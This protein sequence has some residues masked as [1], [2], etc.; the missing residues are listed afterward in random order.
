[1]PRSLLSAALVVTCAAFLAGCIVFRSADA[2]PQGPFGVV[3]VNAVVCASGYD[4]NAGQGCTDY[5]RSGNAAQE[6]RT[7]RALLGYLVPRGT[8]GPTSFDATLDVAWDAGLTFVSSS[9][10]TRRLD[11][12]FPPPAGFVWLGYHS[13]PFTYRVGSSPKQFSVAADFQVPQGP[14][15]APFA[16]PFKAQVVVGHGPDPFDCGTYCLDSVRPAGEPGA[17]T[18][19]VAVNDAGLLG[20]A[21]VTAARGSTASIPFTLA[22][23]G[24]DPGA[25]LALGA[26]TD[27]PGATATAPGTARPT[28]T[29][30][31]PLTV[32]VPV[33]ADAAPGSYAVTL[34]ASLGGQ[35]RTQTRT[36]VVAGPPENQERPEISGAQQAGSVL[37]GS[38]GT[39]SGTPAPSFSRRWLRCNAG[40][41]ACA[42]IEG[43]TGA[44]HTVSG[45]DV[46][47]TLRLRVTA[48]NAGGV[49]ERD[50]APT[51]TIVALPPV[52]APVPPPVPDTTA[53]G[54]TLS[55]LPK[56]VKRRAFLRGITF[57]VA[58]DEAAALSAGLLASARKVTLARASA[59]E[60]LLG[61]AR[62]A[63]GTGVATLKLR[64]AKRLVGRARRFSVRV[65]VTG[66]DGA[67]N[68][69][70]VRR[71]VKVR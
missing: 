50:S 51:G 20:G 22:Y 32:A 62:A 38:D 31:T 21:P 61:S 39:W 45:A 17:T 23:E 44:T 55:G 58:R 5:G 4:N 18:F 12:S 8:R 57:T 65:E 46:G 60:L 37:T 29:S 19:S 70:T 71:T 53:P 27:L 6:D 1:M 3:R 24:A 41:A 69:A 35:S 49:T 43:A 34:T 2:V 47:R 68:Q 13:N 67:G 10:Y 63:R 25:D 9:G 14:D 52:A 26:S 15:G 36:L 40:G 11:E 54:L 59:F 56:S 28:G 33:P 48:T 30:Q 66:T 16:G 42:E 7:T 64:P